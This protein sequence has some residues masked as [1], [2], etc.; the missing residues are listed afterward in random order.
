MVVNEPWFFL[1]HRLPVARGALAAGYE[2]HI[3]TRAGIGVDE[4]KKEGFVHHLIP[5]TRSSANP[6]QELKT[7]FAL[8]KLYRKLK[9]DIVHHVTIKPV[10]YGGFSAYLS[11][12]PSV[13][14]AISGLG[15]VFLANGAFAKLRRFM[16]IN[17]YRFIFKRNNTKVIF[18]NPDDLALFGKNKLLREGCAKLIKGSGVD[19]NIFKPTSEPAGP[20]VII[21]VARMLWDKGVGEF[22]EAAGILKKRGVAGRFLLVGDIDEGNPKTINKQQIEDWCI[23]NNIEWAGYCD[24]MPKVLAESHIACL[25]S[26][27][28]GLPKTLIEAAAA[29]RP[30]VTTDVP[31]CREAVKNCV[32]GLLVPP[33]DP[34]ALANALEVLML[35]PK[36]RIEMGHAG[37]ILAEEEFSVEK[38]VK[39]T[40]DLYTEVMPR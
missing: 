12:I 24:D 1:S 33:Q 23:S 32:N 9:P 15:F 25:P 2:V 13:I 5:F 20:P 27:R 28:E 10:L 4:I 21:L 30:I 39:E 6:V 18:Q 35:D 8:I 29:G 40:L 31:G 16:V 3:A 19:I 7:I 11:K 38:V 37:R 26:Y 14:N 17:A 36:L 34:V 22:I